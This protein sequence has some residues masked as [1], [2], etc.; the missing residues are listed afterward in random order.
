M[1][2]N[3]IALTQY[4]SLFIKRSKLQFVF[5]LLYHFDVFFRE[6]CDVSTIN[7]EE[8]TLVKND[9]KPHSENLI[10]PP[11]TEELRNSSNSDISSSFSDDDDQETESEYPNVSI[12]PENAR[13]TNFNG[14]QDSGVSFE[15]EKPLQSKLDSPQRTAIKENSKMDK[16]VPI[17]SSEILDI[18]AQND[19]ENYIKEIELDASSITDVGLENVLNFAVSNEFSIN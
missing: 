9:E 15:F 1:A 4:D 3:T 6:F 16:S 18:D 8:W 12:V 5:T 14:D 17:Y 19:E 13:H 7:K 10:V 2:L 11:H